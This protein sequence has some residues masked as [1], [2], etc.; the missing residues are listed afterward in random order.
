MQQIP[1]NTAPESDTEDICPL[2]LSSVLWQQPFFPVNLHSNTVVGSLFPSSFLF[3]LSLPEA[4]LLSHCSFHFLYP[5]NTSPKS[6]FVILSPSFLHFSFSTHSLFWS[7]LSFHPPCWFS[8]VMKGSVSLG[9]CEA[10]SG[11]RNYDGWSN[12]QRRLSPRGLSPP[13]FLSALMTF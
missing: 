6:A 12:F 13:C 1:R 10:V 8:E 9:R 11:R 4:F 5:G 2:L 7:I 3:L